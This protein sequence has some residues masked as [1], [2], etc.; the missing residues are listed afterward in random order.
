MTKAKLGLVVALL[1]LIAIGSINIYR[2]TIEL[3]NLTEEKQQLKEDE[4]KTR[5][6]Y[7]NKK[8]KMEVQALKEA[9]NNDNQLLKSLSENFS[10]Y[11]IMNTLANEFFSGY[12]TWSDGDSYRG[13]KEKLKSITD[14]SIL[15]DE[16]LFDDGKDTTGDDYINTTGLKSE[17]SKIEAFPESE[18]K[19]LVK[20]EYK[21]W[22]DDKKSDAGEGTKYFILEFDREKHKIKKLELVFSSEES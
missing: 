21:S 10:S 3:K 7:Q 13:R 20:V 19:A 4:L 5:Q 6:N 18:E 22:F 15:N 1:G 9:K 14:E 2:N 11:E 12:F 17:V 8:E 16:K